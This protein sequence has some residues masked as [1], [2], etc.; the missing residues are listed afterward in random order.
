MVIERETDH[1]HA[2]YE[3]SDY[4]WFLVQT[5]YDTDQPDPENDQR[6]IPVELKLSQRGNINFSEDVLMQQMSAWPTFNIATIFTDIL[7]PG[8]GYTNTT[9]WY[10]NNPE[11]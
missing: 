4:M 11:K 5:N 8:T 9:V 3:L 7:I 1:T 2:Y 6:R 10:G